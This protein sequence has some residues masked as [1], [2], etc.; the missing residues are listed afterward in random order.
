VWEILGIAAILGKDA[1]GRTPCGCGECHERLD[2]EI[3]L[4]QLVDSDWL[5]HFFVPA[6]RFW[7]NIGFT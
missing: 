7:E 4:G 3:R 5:V 2:L 1:A 6:M